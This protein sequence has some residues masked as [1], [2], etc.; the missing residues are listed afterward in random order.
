MVGVLSVAQVCRGCGSLVQS[1]LPVTTRNGASLGLTP[2]STQTWQRRGLAALT[3]FL[4]ILYFQ[5]RNR[6]WYISIDSVVSYI[7]FFFF[8]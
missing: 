1:I 2:C 6:M 4:C 8:K 3:E 7:F 5:A